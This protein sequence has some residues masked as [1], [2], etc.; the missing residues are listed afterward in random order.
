M[1]PVD[2]AIY[3][4]K[5]KTQWNPCDAFLVAVFLEKEKA[6]GKSNEYFATVELNGEMTRG[7][8]AIYHVTG[9]EKTPNVIMIE[10]VNSD[11]CKNLLLWTATPE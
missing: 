7:Q 6:I 5:N 11:I 4:P 9:L 1:N 10:T 3:K 2:D 8:V